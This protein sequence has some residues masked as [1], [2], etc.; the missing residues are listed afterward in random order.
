MRFMK[1]RSLRKQRNLIMKHALSKLLLAQDQ[2]KSLEDFTLG[3]YALH[4]SVTGRASV[5]PTV[6]NK[7]GTKSNRFLWYLIMHVTRKSGLIMTG[8]AYTL[9][10]HTSIILRL[11]SE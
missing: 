6:K 7:S 4:L 5:M 10:M 2:L 8:I 9:P 3:Q 11:K 1:L